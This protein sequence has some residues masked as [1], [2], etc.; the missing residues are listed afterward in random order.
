MAAWKGPCRG[1]DGLVARACL[2]P[3]TAWTSPRITEVEGEVHLSPR[4]MA[5][6]ENGEFKISKL[7]VGCLCFVNEAEYS[8]MT[9]NLEHNG[10]PY[11]S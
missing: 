3:E 7:V 5:E 11:G 9:M 10:G 4:Q 2:A 8:S 6:E 1:S